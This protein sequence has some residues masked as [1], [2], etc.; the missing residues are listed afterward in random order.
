MRIARAIA[1]ACVIASCTTDPHR[2]P[3][4]ADLQHA[5]TD[6]SFKAAVS[7][8][9]EAEKEVLAGYMIRAS[10]SLSPEQRAKTIGE[11]ISAQ[12]K[13]LA[14]RAEE[15]KR[16]AEEEKRKT[17]AALNE[18]E[19][20]RG[21]ERTAMRE[22][23]SIEIVS[24]ARPPRDLSRKQFGDELAVTLKIKNTGKKP[25]K[26]VAGWL[27]ATDTRTTVRTIRQA[28][29]PGPIAPGE[30]REWTGKLPIDAPTTFV[31]SA[32]TW[33]PWEYTFDD[34]SKLWWG[35]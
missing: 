13:F 22:A 21:D 29:I 8:L 28:S 16:Q 31:P 30:T 9:P 4:P 25:L 10:L 20:K 24:L 5:D 6:T 7:K 15:E 17:A 1:L 26:L 23:A 3:M 11:A 27:D 18:A 14:L 34:G 32:A 35:K 19:G 12:Q 2:E 33:A